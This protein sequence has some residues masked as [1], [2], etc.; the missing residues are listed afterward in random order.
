MLSWYSVSHACVRI[1]DIITD[2]IDIHSGVK[3]G[4]IMSPHMYN[5]YVDDLMTKLLCEK[6][7]C[8]IGHFLYCAIFYADDII[9]MSA[10][11]R[12]MQ[13]RLTSVMNMVYSMVFALM[14]RKVN[15]FLQESMM[16]VQEFHLSLEIMLLI[17]N[18][19]V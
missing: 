19:I 5:V 10:S 14:P 2:N 8:M 15:G 1:D 4:G 3:Q 7:G 11:R 6:L 12:K 17:M 9:L 18:W 13:K 16:N